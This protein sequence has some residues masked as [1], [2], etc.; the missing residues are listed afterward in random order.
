[1]DSSVNLLFG[2]RCA[3]LNHVGRVVK[4]HKC[5][6][7]VHAVKLRE[8][9]VHFRARPQSLEA[10]VRRIDRWIRYANS[11]VAE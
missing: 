4:M 7:N 6:A 11:V 9:T 1:M 8:A 5:A 2:G 3:T 10:C